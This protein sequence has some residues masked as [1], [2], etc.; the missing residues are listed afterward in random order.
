MLGEGELLD[1]AAF[2]CAAIWAF[3]AAE[4][5]AVAWVGVLG[6]KLVDGV[7][8]FAV[9]RRLA[10]ASEIKL[11]WDASTTVIPVLD[12]EPVAKSASTIPI[13]LTHCPLLCA[14]TDFPAALKLASPSAQI[15]I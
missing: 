3:L 1:A 14:P 6:V 11:I 15:G 2:A 7:T 9:K 8:V 10:S 4:F 13:T 12:Q 5:K